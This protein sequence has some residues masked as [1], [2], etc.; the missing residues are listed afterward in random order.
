MDDS[1]AWIIAAA[2]AEALR[3]VTYFSLAWFLAYGLI[4]PLA[5]VTLVQKRLYKVP[6]PQSLWAVLVSHIAFGL[7]CMNPYTLFG[8]LLWL[9]RTIGHAWLDRMWAPLFA[10]YLV[11]LPVVFDL[12]LFRLIARWRPLRVYLSRVPLHVEV[13][14][15]LVAVGLANVAGYAAFFLSR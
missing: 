9:D 5:K 11:V 10:G 3:R 7:V 14:A 8:G 12:L 4:G 13:V 1:S 2:L 15:A 6:F